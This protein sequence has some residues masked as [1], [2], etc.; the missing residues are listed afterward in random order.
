MKEA[1]HTQRNDDGL[2]LWSITTWG[3]TQEEAALKLAEALI[4][5]RGKADD[6][7]RTPCPDC[8]KL[9]RVTNRIDSRYVC[10]D[11]WER[12]YQAKNDLG[13]ERKP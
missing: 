2:K 5:L 6:E 7:G 3:E 1:T 8:G 4:G 12:I 10:I 9:V 13:A 11:C